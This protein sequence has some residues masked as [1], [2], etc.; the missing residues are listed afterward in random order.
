M[1]DFIHYTH[2]D[3]DR[4][5][6]TYDRWWS[7]SLRRPITSIITHG[8]P[9]KKETK[10]P[11]LNYNTSWDTSI[12][13]TDFLESHEV[14]LD[15]IR[16]HGDAYPFFNTMAFGPGVLAAFMG[17]TPIGTPHTVWMRAPA[18]DI[19]IEELHFEF[20]DYHLKKF[21]TNFEF[22]RCKLESIEQIL[23]Y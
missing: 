9:T 2:E 14:Y 17:C 20:Q 22:Q 3:F 7:G 23:Q 6:D 16:F 21:V 15:T 5:R 4:L 10:K 12:P 18:E 19:P 13:V 1:T 8:H 11:S